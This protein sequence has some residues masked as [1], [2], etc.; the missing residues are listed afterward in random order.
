MKPFISKKGTA[1]LRDPESGDSGS[2]SETRDSMKKLVEKMK[3]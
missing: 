2:G 3:E 1:P